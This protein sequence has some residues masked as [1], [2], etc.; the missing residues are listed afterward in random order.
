MDV[1]AISRGS[2]S[3]M[4]VTGPCTTSGRSSNTYRCLPHVSLKQQRLRASSLRP[5][6]NT[7]VCCRC[8]LAYLC[9]T[10]IL[11]GGEQA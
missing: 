9:T 4:L 1:G 8:P 10:P 5:L 6:E 2:A 3:D 7:M 11:K